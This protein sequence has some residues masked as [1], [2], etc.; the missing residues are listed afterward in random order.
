MNIKKI[1]IFA[2]NQ[3]QRKQRIIT[4]MKMEPFPDTL[5]KQPVPS[6]RKMSGI[7]MKYVLTDEQSAWLCK[8]FPEVENSILM[9]ASGM[10][11]SALHRFARDLGLTK[12]DKGIRGI[13]KRQAA[14]I[15]RLC[16]ENG[17]YDSLRGKPVSE[18]CLQA[19]AKMWQ[20]IRDGKREHPFKIM[21]RTNPRKYKKWLERRSEA[22]REQ[23]R[24]EIR[25]EI[26]GLPR[27]TKL[28]IVVMN[29]FTRSQVCHRYYA[30][31][32]GYILMEDCSEQGGERY[33]I[34]YDDL[35]ERAPIFERNLIKDG[36]KLMKYET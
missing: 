5:T 25:R 15:K 11:H 23:V 34:Y 33:N 35:T 8:W 17:Y 27:K 6:G 32:R 9:E 10:T 16:E 29:K 12:S 24:K 13:K 21:K 14:H 4:M 19:T 2:A 22:R 1:L 31:K 28:K 36:F 30:L 3:T 26:Y 20:E 18:A 7:V